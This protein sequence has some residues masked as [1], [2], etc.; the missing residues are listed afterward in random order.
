M[1][2]L[3]LLLTGSMMLLHS[4]NILSQQNT[5]SFD[6]DGIKVI[7]K[8]VP[9]EVVAVRL[10]IRGGT[11]NYPLVK[12]GLETLTYEMV[13]YGGTQVT[14]A[15]EFYIKANNLGIGLSG[16]S[17]YDYGYLGMTALKNYWDESWTLWAETLTQ[18]KMSPEAFEDF[19]DEIYSRNRRANTAPEEEIDQLST[20][21]TYSG[22]DY[23]K[24]PN[25][26]TESLYN[27][28]LED[29]TEHYSKILT[30][31]NCFV[32]VVGNVSSDDIKQK[33]QSTFGTLPSGTITATIEPTELRSP[34]VNIQHSDLDIN[35]IQGRMPAPERWSEEDIPNRLAMNLLSDR[36]IEVLTEEHEVAYA[37]SAFA[38][39]DHRYPSNGIYAATTSPV[40]SIK[41]MMEVIEKVKEEGFS[42]EEL[43]KKKPSFITYHYLA[44]ETVDAQAHVL[45]DAEMQGDWQLAQDITPLV[46]Q[47]T[48]EDVN[49][50]FRKYSTWINWTYL[51]NASQVVSEDFPQPKVE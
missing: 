19:R 15:V 8:Q 11:A 50:V 27:L 28:T 40:K 41:L 17:G 35:H 36:F 4:E 43:E 24:N 48:V 14:A 49:A 32:V 3:S 20:V 51:G 13:L 29:V 33:V 21:Y 18:P 39:E 6:V 5:T 46:Q 44:Q 25:G 47:T 38:G 12:E 16:K 10:Y 1:K 37:P 22:T 42:T 23:E 7:H 31:G 9:N 45:G 2:I 34:G 26:T 30:K